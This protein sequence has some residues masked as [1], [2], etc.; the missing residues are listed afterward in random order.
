[1]PKARHVTYVTWLRKTFRPADTRYIAL[2]RARQAPLR[3]K[4]EY[5]VVLCT[6]EV[7]RAAYSAKV[8]NT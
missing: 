5:L 8:G 1:V 7:C 6:A 3:R 2:Q 4:T